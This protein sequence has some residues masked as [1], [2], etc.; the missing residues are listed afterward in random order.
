MR[1]ELESPPALGHQ[2]AEGPD[3][4][5]CVGTV[6]SRNV[7]MAGG[8]SRENWGGGEKTEGLREPH[9]SETDETGKTGPFLSLSMSRKQSQRQSEKCCCGG[10]S[11]RI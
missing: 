11:S 9:M 8:W 4:G 10:G 5:H 3:V 6:R 1:V 2:E 7:Q